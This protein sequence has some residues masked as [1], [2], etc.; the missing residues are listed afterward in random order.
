MGIFQ[1]KSHRNDDGVDMNSGRRN[2]THFISVPVN[3]SGELT[4]KFTKFKRSFS[5]DS[6]LKGA[7]VAP[8]KLHLTLAMLDLSNREERAQKI[9]LISKILHQVSSGLLQF[10]ISLK[11]LGLMR[12]ST[13]A[14]QVLH[15]NLDRQHEGHD[16]LA[17][18]NQQIR[19]ELLE[20]AISTNDSSFYPHVTLINTKYIKRGKKV[21]FDATG[22]LRHNVDLDWGTVVISSM[23]ISKIHSICPTT[24]YYQDEGVVELKTVG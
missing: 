13:E 2:F 9:E 5:H 3:E 12:G 14:A 6:S 16:T 22:A 7:F 21:T 20:N 17:R 24:G 23:H 10:S 15:V 1:S 11:G 18:L 19:Q 8:E 4:K